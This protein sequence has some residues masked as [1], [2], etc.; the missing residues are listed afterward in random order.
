M[1][2]ITGYRCDAEL[3]PAANGYVGSGTRISDGKRVFFKQFDRYVAPS[4]S[5]LA[6]GTPSA[7][8]RQREFE[9]YRKH[10]VELDARL[11]TACGAGSCLVPPL[12]VVQCGNK[13][14]HVTELV[15]TSRAV[16]ITDVHWRYPR[17]VVVEMF[18][19][20][21]RTVDTVHRQGIVLIDIK[22][23]NA[24]VLDEGGVPRCLLFDYDD[25]VFAG[26]VPDAA[27]VVS[28]PEYFSPELAAYIS[29]ADG[30]DSLGRAGSPLARAIGRRH[31]IFALGLLLHMLLAGELPNAGTAAW[32]AIAR[33][34]DEALELSKLLRTDDR[35]LIR[36]MLRRNPAE[37]PTS[38]AQILERMDPRCT[39][40][41]RFATVT[42]KGA[43]RRTPPARPTSATPA[44]PKAAPAA[45]IVFDPPRDGIFAGVTP[46]E[47]GRVKIL[48]ADGSTLTKRVAELA[49]YG[50]GDQVEPVRRRAVERYGKGW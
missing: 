25:A 34:G 6:S 10:L 49:L 33:G 9:D 13:L 38:C 36:W 15:D 12:D 18:K 32:K 43:T 42:R 20:V 39:A 1:P 30:D 5:A 46:L 47:G 16:T 28:T 41:P 50:L 48:C 23:A 26:E 11:R 44:A 45:D 31:D 37:R 35:E 3:E 4:E 2:K 22:D 24:F 27:K 14:V 7:L 29:R 21:L 17:S 40:V 8:R 19:D